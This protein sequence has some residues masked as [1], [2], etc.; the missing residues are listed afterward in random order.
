MNDYRCRDDGYCCLSWLYENNPV[1]NATVIETANKTDAIKESFLLFTEE[2]ENDIFKFY[3]AHE[4]GFDQYRIHG[5][6]HVARAVIFSEVMS[7]YFQ[8]KGESI[9]FDYVRRMTGLHDAG[10]EGNGL[11]RWENQSADLLYQHLKL[12]GMPH[13]QAYQKSRNIIKATADNSIEYQIFQSADCIDIMRPCT[14]RGGREGFNSA[15]LS[16]LKDSHDAEDVKF[17]EDLI[18]EA[19]DFIKISEAKKFSD[20][21]DSQGFMKKLFQIIDHDRNSF[22]IL[23]SILD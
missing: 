6:M 17:R 3:E 22:K 19:W 20:F 13:D 14:G 8:S 15:F 12:K 5:R 4:S 21:K 10:R 7:R 1:Q 23:S 11:D 18:E 16:F 2:L 9:D